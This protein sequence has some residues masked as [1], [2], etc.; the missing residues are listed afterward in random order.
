MFG[1]LVG[2]QERFKSTGINNTLAV[3]SITLVGEGVHFLQRSLLLAIPEGSCVTNETNSSPFSES[4]PAG[5]YVHHSSK[6]S[7]VSMASSVPNLGFLDTSVHVSWYTA[8]PLSLWNGR[9]LLSSD[10]PLSGFPPDPG[11]PPQAPLSTPPS[12]PPR[13]LTGSP[14]PG[15][16][17][18][19]SLCIASQ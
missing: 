5:T 2:K 6:F 7:K 1:V 14:A 4:L 13:T 19:G 11:P 9:S 3:S 15:A 17:L 12:G 18:H 16:D 10:H 8:L